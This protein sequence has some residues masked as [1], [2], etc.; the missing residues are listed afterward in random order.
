MV[1][2]NKNDI[3][4]PFDLYIIFHEYLLPRGQI[5]R[6]VSH[7]LRTINGEERIIYLI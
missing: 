2:G 6:P 7:L 1:M 4:F 3:F 5:I